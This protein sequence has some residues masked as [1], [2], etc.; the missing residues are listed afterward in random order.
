MAAKLKKLLP[1]RFIREIVIGDG[2]SISENPLRLTAPELEIKIDGKTKIINL[3]GQQQN[4]FINDNKLTTIITTKS[5]L[6]V[7]SLKQAPHR[8]KYYLAP[9][10]FT[11]S[12]LLCNRDKTPLADI[13]ELEIM[14]QFT[15][16]IHTL[17]FNLEEEKTMLQLHDQL[18]TLIKD[19]LDLK[20]RE[21]LPFENLMQ[22]IYVGAK[23]KAAAPGKYSSHFNYELD[24]GDSANDYNGDGELFY[25]E[26][27][28]KIDAN[29]DSWAPAHYYMDSFDLLPENDIQIPKNALEKAIQR[30]KPFLA[31]ANEDNQ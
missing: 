27:S 22:T 3:H 18:T 8:L 26:L 11:S 28:E 13:K 25:K 21:Q 24:N 14:V 5:K 23:E 12:L 31:L 29:N 7:K 4:N 10:L 1:G 20:Q 19:F 2:N 15:D 30:L 6:G 16:K 17:T 9:F